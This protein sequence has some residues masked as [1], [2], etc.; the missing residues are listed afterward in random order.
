MLRKRVAVVSGGNRGLGLETCKQLSLREYHVVLGSRDL[1]KG[2]HAADELRAHGADVEVHQ[3]V[4]TVASSIAELRTSAEQR[5][6][7][8]DVLV[9][10]A[11]IIGSPN[12]LSVLKMTDRQLEDTLENNFFSALHMCQALV[13]LMK[14]ANFGRVVNVSSGMGQL[15]EMGAGAPPYRF[16]KAALNV[17]TRILSVELE[18]TNVLVNS[19]CPGWVRTDMGGESA[20][21]SLS[22]GASGIVWAATLPDG[23]PTGGFFRRGEALPW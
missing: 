4:V 21:L 13:P 20:P 16:S 2:Q 8:V 1:A 15:S 23:G 9:N 17:L 3:L 12:D 11:G 6:G 10:S 18:G 19:V 7:R 14:R 22:E 5:W